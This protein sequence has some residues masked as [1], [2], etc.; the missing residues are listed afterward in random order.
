MDPRQTP[1]TR[2]HPLAIVE[3]TKGIFKIVLYPEICPKTVENFVKLAKKGFYNGLKFHRVEPGFV[4]QGGDPNGDGTGGPG[5]S[6]PNEH[7]GPLRHNRGAVAMANAGRDTAGS[8]F[9]VV[10]SK[11]APNL[12][13]KEPDGM[14]KYT[15]FGQVATG[16]N[17]AEKIQV[18]DKILS[19][20]IVE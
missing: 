2:R 14:S 3:T 4:I 12:D 8:Q 1:K 9:Y 17:I 7:N 5:W 11:P 6:I 10:I 19:I 18:G 16:Q 15:I 13:A 20:K